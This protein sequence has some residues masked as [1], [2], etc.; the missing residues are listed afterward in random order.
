MRVSSHWGGVVIGI[1]RSRPKVAFR[2]ASKK[3]LKSPMKMPPLPKRE[4]YVF[5]GPHSA[6]GCIL[7]PSPGH[8][9]SIAIALCWVSRPPSAPDPGRGNSGTAPFSEIIFAGNRHL[10]GE[11][12]SE[13]MIAMNSCYDHCLRLP[14]IS[15]SPWD[16]LSP[17]WGSR[18]TSG[19]FGAT[20]SRSFTR[21]F[22]LLNL[23]G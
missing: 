20:S 21:F 15:R 4:Q 17:R 14:Q 18:R 5:V 1:R 23:R 6:T 11:P 8:A 9:R 12:V 13:S 3:W 19:L 10:D 7:H 22:G 2:I 16:V